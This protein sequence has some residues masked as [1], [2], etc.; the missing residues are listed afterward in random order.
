MN[1]TKRHH[2]MTL[3]VIASLALQPLTIRFREEFSERNSVERSWMLQL[4]TNYQKGARVTDQDL[5]RIWRIYEGAHNLRVG[6]KLYAFSLICG[7]EDIS[8]WQKEF[9]SLALSEDPKYV[10]TAIDAVM[11]KLERGTEREKIILSNKTAVLDRL[12]KF[13]EDNK[14]DTTIHRDAVKINELRKPYIGMTSP[15]EA[16]RPA[17]R[18]SVSSADETPIPDERTSDSSELGSF[19]QRVGRE[20]ILMFAGIIGICIIVILIW[21]K[22]L[23]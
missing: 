22:K 17:R 12:V 20:R 7:L 11:W 23:K 19:V 14:S 15:A 1:H 4:F 13:A 16:Q 2:A 10:K 6:D 18:F 21:R 3:L 9:D 5:N 8:K